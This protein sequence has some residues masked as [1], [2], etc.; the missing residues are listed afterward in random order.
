MMHTDSTRQLVA[1]WFEAAAERRPFSFALP[2][3]IERVTV[4]RRMEV[5]QKKNPAIFHKK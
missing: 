4:F 1:D 2:N 3:G 5:I